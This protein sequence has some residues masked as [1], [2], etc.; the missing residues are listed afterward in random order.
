MFLEKKKL[1][2]NKGICLCDL[3][4][5]YIDSYFGIK[6]EDILLSSNAFSHR[7][8]RVVAGVRRRSNKRC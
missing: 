5:C 4:V 1:K 6:G 8:G 3:H 7:C 2:G